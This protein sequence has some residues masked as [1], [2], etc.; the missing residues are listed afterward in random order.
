MGLEIIPTPC[1]CNHAYAVTIETKY[2]EIK[3]NKN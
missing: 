1:P 2:L 3:I